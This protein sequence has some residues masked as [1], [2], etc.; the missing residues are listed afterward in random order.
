MSGRRP[1]ERLTAKNKKTGEITRLLAVW[2]RAEAGYPEHHGQQGSHG[3]ADR[4]MLKAGKDG[5]FFSTSATTR[6]AP[7][8]D[9]QRLGTRHAT[10]NREVYRPRARTSTR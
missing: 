5:D 4:R 6:P 2:P 10:V 7:S 9:F 3:R 1:I 8:G